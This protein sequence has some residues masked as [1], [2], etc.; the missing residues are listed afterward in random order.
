MRTWRKLVR[1]RAKIK[2][3]DKS[4]KDVLIVNRTIIYAIKLWVFN[5]YCINWSDGSWCLSMLWCWNH[6]LHNIIK[7]KQF[8]DDRFIYRKIAKKNEAHITTTP[9]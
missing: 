4:L 5:C 7:I 3:D 8:K 1:R 6:R 2:L 9:K